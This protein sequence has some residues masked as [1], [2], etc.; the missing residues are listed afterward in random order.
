MIGWECPRCHATYSPFVDQCGPCSTPP[1]IVSD[2]TYLPLFDSCPHC[3]G[4]RSSP[5][6][7]ACGREHYGAYS[8]FS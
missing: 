2:R 3:H 8:F 1:S 7:S 6:M 4:S 5:P